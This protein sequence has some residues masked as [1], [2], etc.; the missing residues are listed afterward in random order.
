MSKWIHIIGV[1]GVATS[2]IAVM[3]KK[4]GWRVTGSDK[5]FFPPVSTY[6]NEQGIKI[7]PGFKSSRLTDEYSKHPDLVVFRGTV[8]TKNS[9]LI[10]AERLKL[11]LKTY[12]EIL[13]QYVVKKD[14]SIV[15]TGTYGKTTI[16]ALTV[17]ILQTSKI[18]VSYMLGGISPDLKL[19]IQ[20]ANTETRWSVIEG[21]EFLNSYKD[22]QAKF[23]YYDPTHLVI[24]AVKW[25]HPDLYP[26]ESAY[27]ESFVKLVQRVPK[28]GLIVANATDENVVEVCKYAKC[29]VSYYAVDKKLALVK[30]DWYLLKES[31]PLPSFIRESNGKPLEIV[32]FKKMILGEY[33]LENL[34]AGAALTYEIGIVKERIQEA[35]QDFHGIKR[36]M[37]IRYQK[38]E[39]VVIDDFGSSPVKAK[40]TL[41]TLKQEFPKHYLAAVFEP[42]SGSRVKRAR[43]LYRGAFANADLVIFPRFTGVGSGHLEKL[44]SPENLAEIIKNDALKVE[45]YLDDE[46]LLKN[47]QVLFK[48]Y[49]R[50]IVIFLGSHSFRGMIEKFVKEI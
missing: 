14:K 20:A 8:S 12:P 32:P 19:N 5:G 30:P 18:P 25:E 10:A 29:Q 43:S 9:E 27:L 46:E 35:I 28:Q 1:S 24:N 49:Q 7:L 36:R 47:L 39:K 13:K 33:N 2:G 34:L 21:D 17:K 22:K 41:E 42:N 50:I 3:F 38:N 48:S 23:F 26:T 16:T 15:V 4:L 37:E 45:V 11:P 40:A 44:M 6:L 31:Q